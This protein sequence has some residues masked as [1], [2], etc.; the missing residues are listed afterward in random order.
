VG[1]LDFTSDRPL[2]ISGAGVSN[3]GALF[4]SA[5]NG[6]WAGA[7]ALA[8]D[9]TIGSAYTLTLSGPISGAHTLTVGGQ[10][11]RLTNASNNFAALTVAGGVLELASQSPIPV[12]ATITA[13]SS[14]R[15]TVMPGASINRALVLNG[16]TLGTSFDDSAVGTWAGSITGSAPSILDAFQPDARLVVSGNVT[17]TFGRYGRGEV[18]LTGNNNVTLN[19]GTGGLTAQSNGALQSAIV[20]DGG[21]VQLKG[22]ITLGTLNA[23]TPVTINNGGRLLVTASTTTVRSFTLNT[24]SIQASSG[25]TLT[26]QGANITGGFLRGP[27]THSIGQSSILNG[28]TSLP[29]S[30]VVQSG[31]VNVNTF[32]NSGAFTSNAALYWDGGYNTA[33]GQL[34]VN[35]MLTAPPL[36]TTARSPST[37]AAR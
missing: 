7:I 26:Y 12:A 20:T 5:F 3:G 36:R 23:P 4:S 22:N 30:N 15:V 28:V 31:T 19:V 8:A 27:G 17:G 33:S 29:G 9:S 35:S 14:A 10:K 18:V 13:N 25:A 34:I 32:T 2:Q 21:T 24:G 1:V 37:T 11:I 16:G 6:T